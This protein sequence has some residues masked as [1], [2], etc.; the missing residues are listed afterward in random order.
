MK[1]NFIII[2]IAVL[3]L[4][5]GSCTDWLDTRP[6][7]EI[8]LDDYWQSEAQAQ[9]VL[10]A[11]YRGLITDGVMER[12][13]IWGELRSDNFTAGSGFPNER[14]DMSKILEV[15]ITPTN[16][17]CAW[18]PFYSVINNC[19][20]F[21]H[22]APGVVD[23]DQN[24]TEGKLHS[25]EAEVRAIRALCYFYLV[26]TYKEVP[27]VGTPSISDTQDYKVFKSSERAVL[28]SIIAD[29]TIARKYARID[30]GNVAQNKGRITRNAVNA[31]LA[32]VYLWDQQYDK[33]VEMC[34]EVLADQSLGLVPG[35]S[36]FENVFYRGN[37]IESIFELQFDENVQRNNT[38][39]NLYGIQ[40]D[41]Q[42]ELSFPLYLIKGDYSP[43]KYKV[44]TDIESEKDLRFKDFI[45][46]S[47]GDA[48]GIYSVF[49]YAGIMRTENQQEI[50]TY[51]WRSTTPN[52]IVYRVSDVLLMKAEAL[53]APANP[54]ELAMLEALLLVNVTYQR[55]NPTSAGLDFTVY[56]TKGILEKLI[57]RERQR[58]LMFEGKRWFDLMRVARRNNSP[59]SLLT[60]LPQLTGLQFN[61]MSVMDAL[62]LPVPQSDMDN[63]ENMVQNPFYEEYNTSK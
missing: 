56:N 34:N 53:V 30:F 6:V 8:V 3:T 46:Q 16:R 54:S 60:Y 14:I 33:C 31:I 27:W 12:M 36:M 39:R 10:M 52:W 61:K 17:Y 42:G 37:S 22:Y 29:L 59:T 62:Y 50:S 49:K 38:T 63:N 2:L 25:L 9:A 5:M 28:D 23:A 19:N 57:L 35:E 48:T 24:F 7:S 58:E 4:G 40:G 44:G 41:I 32:D 47:L 43:F 20:T 1:R 11:C 21:L 45:V 18:A 55:S 51:S 15:N 13:L 26:R